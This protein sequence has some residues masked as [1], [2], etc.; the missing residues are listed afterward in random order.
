MKKIKI[1]ILLLFI[2]LN[3]Y[4][5]TVIKDTQTKDIVPDA[6]ILNKKGQLI[7]ESDLNGV[8]LLFSKYKNYTD[9][10]VIKHIAYKP[11]LSTGKEL[12]ENKTLFLEQRINKL[13]EVTV[14]A[15]YDYTVIKG[16]FRS[17]QINNSIP[18]YYT[19]GIV[20][21]Y[22]HKKEKKR[23]KSR[24]L[25]NR[26]YKNNDYLE[27][28]KKR[29]LMMTYETS[30][31]FYYA[32]FWLPYRKSDYFFDKSTIHSDTVIVKNDDK[33]NV[34]KAFV[35]K[36]NGRTV[37]FYDC[38][39]PKKEKKRSLFGYT[40]IR[41]GMTFSEFL[42]TSDIENAHISN[43][44]SCKL[45][46]QFEYKHKKEKDFTR[47]EQIDEFYVLEIRKESKK[48]V[49]KKR[50]KND[51]GFGPTLNK[52]N[53]EWLKDYKEQIPPLDNSIKKQLGKQLILF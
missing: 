43:L 3:S 21:Y 29:S 27:K 12:Q 4:S 5:Q 26:A 2:S 40:T 49:K 15:D 32:N 6:Y 1:S 19:D 51:Y 47:I 38:L 20:E 10:L 53:M 14:T 25:N 39:Y 41:K 42:N 44:N 13:P 46:N 22:I 24:L 37:V 11:F 34:G 48:E 36:K 7:G 45:S 9:S 16:Y 23:V 30:G 17:Y 31:V 52:E 28:E 35:D 18:T 33:E 50:L 8:I